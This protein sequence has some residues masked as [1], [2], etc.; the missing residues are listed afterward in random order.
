LLLISKVID[1][2]YKSTVKREMGKDERD[3]TQRTRDS[4]KQKIFNAKALRGKGTK[5]I[6]KSG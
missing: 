3:L 1:Y 6:L 5:R 4:E 2:T